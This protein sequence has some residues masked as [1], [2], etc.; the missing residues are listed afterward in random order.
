MGNSLL[1]MN[2]GKTEINTVLKIGTQK[3]GVKRQY[4]V[5][6]KMPATITPGVKFRITLVYD[7]IEFRVASGSQ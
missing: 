5:P 4:M 1:M 3:S 6:V 2:R 7:G